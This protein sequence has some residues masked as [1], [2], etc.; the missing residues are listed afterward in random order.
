VTKDA[1]S[2][3]GLSPWREMPQHRPTCG[4][5][6][7]GVTKVQASVTKRPKAPQPSREPM[8]GVNLATGQLT[9]PLCQR[10]GCTKPVAVAKTGRPARY[11]SDTCRQRAHRQRARRS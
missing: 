6:V 8:L 9:A 5:R 10:S 2:E 3:C 1:C 4:R 7:G 11:C